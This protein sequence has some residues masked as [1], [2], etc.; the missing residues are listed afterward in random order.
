MRNAFRRLMVHE[1][2]H[3]TRTGF[4]IQGA[5]QLAAGVTRK[6]RV[7]PYRSRVVRDGIERVSRT[8]AAIESDVAIDETDCI[9]LPDGT[10]PPILSVQAKPDINGQTSHYEVLF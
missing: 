1:V 7:K 8:L 9:A 6:A 2:I 5:P 10:T 3:Q 4:T